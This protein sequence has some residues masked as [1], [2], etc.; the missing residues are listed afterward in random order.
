MSLEL[1][2]KRF[3]KLEEQL[4]EII[5][6]LFQNNVAPPAQSIET[7]ADMVANGDFSGLRKHNK[8]VRSRKGSKW[9]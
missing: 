8:S 6:L 2:E 4:N 7:L 5:R 9:Q 3:A 1:F